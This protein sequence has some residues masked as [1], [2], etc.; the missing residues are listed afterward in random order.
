MLTSEQFTAG[1][2]QAAQYTD[3]GNVLFCGESRQQQIGLANHS[4]LFVILQEKTFMRSQPTRPASVQV[5]LL[6]TN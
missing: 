2:H 5:F 3:L 6:F 4:S 1:T